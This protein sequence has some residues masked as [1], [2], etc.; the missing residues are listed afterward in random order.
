MISSNTKQKRKTGY[1]PQ[2]A[3]SL[4]LEYRVW[5]VKD[6][7]LQ[8]CFSPCSLGLYIQ[9]CNVF[10]NRL[11]YWNSS[12]RSNSP[13]IIF[14]SLSENVICHSHSFTTSADMWAET[15]PLPALLNI[16]FDSLR[17]GNSTN[18]E[19]PSCD[20]NNDS[21]TSDKPHRVCSEEIVGV[22]QWPA[23]ER[24]RGKPAGS[25][26]PAARGVVSVVGFGET[27]WSP[28]ASMKRCAVLI[29]S[30]SARKVRHIFWKV[31]RLSWCIFVR[32][33]F[34]P[35]ILLHCLWTFTFP[36]VFIFILLQLPLFVPCTSCFFFKYFY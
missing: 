32:D 22:Y 13:K 29:I 11:Q 16:P 25:E 12:F 15:V 30:S 28:F 31:S 21:S 19:T 9:S 18:S 20:S 2:A 17:G 23:C 5:N 3:K 4:F 34:A 1:N 24:S 27:S 33:N 26:R 8:R 10:F 7:K 14:L 35:L 36:I 6:G